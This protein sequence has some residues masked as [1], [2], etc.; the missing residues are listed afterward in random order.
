MVALG[1]CV[2]GCDSVGP[3]YEVPPTDVATAWQQARDPHL[4]NEPADLKSWWQVFEDPTLEALIDRAFE[5]N[6]TLQQAALRILESRLI[7]AIAI[8][9]KAPQVQEINGG[10]QRV[11]VSRNAPNTANASRAFGDYSTSFDVGWELDLWGRLRA[12]IDAAEADLIASE[13]DLA[14]A[15]LA[16]AAQTHQR[17]RAFMWR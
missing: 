2:N 10:Y 12:G 14:S 13:A 17:G 15:R 16:L 5:N 7:R 8:G 6:L 4:K 1:L 11:E 3:D 9:Q